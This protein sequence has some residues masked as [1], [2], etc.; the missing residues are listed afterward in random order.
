MVITS[1]NGISITAVL[2]KSSQWCCAA[3][4]KL[5]SEHV[6]TACAFCKRCSINPRVCSRCS[7]Y[8]LFLVCKIGS[9]FILII[10][11]YASQVAQWLM[12]MQ[13]GKSQASHCLNT[14]SCLKGSLGTIVAGDL[15]CPPDSLEMH[16]FRAL[17]PDLHD[18]WEQLH[19]QQPGFT[20]NAPDNSFT[21]P[22]KLP[23]DCDD[24]S[25]R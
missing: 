16:I 2:P 11:H 20:S 12:S 18:C 4:D 17:L 21:K 14:S 9:M 8:T 23:T 22:G 15:N 1:T 10:Y 25:A 19:P 6:T 13:F 7:L 24:I 5:S 3:P